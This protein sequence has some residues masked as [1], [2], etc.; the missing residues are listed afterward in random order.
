MH[1]PMLVSS[2]VGVLAGLTLLF[3]VYWEPIRVFA[4]RTFG[5]I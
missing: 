4:E 3:G 2:V 1:A 5:L